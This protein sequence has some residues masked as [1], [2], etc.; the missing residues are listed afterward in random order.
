[1]A[2]TAEQVMVEIEHEKERHGRR[3]KEIDREERLTY[4]LISLVALAPELIAIGRLLLR[5]RR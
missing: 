4:L 3:K 5:G 1:M 2:K